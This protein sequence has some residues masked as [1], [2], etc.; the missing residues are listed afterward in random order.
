MLEK[1][2]FWLTV[3]TYAGSLAL[4]LKASLQS[5][6][7][8][9]NGREHNADEKW[10]LVAFLCH[11]AILV[12]RAA[13]S[14]HAPFTGLC[15]SLLIFSWGTTFFTIIARRSFGIHSMVNVAVPLV[16]A[17]LL[18]TLAT[19]TSTRPLPPVLRSPWLMIH[20]T[21]AIM[22]YGAFAAA[23]AVGVLRLWQEY[24]RKRGD[25]SESQLTD[26]ARLTS[27]QE[28]A[29][30][31]LISLGFPLM[32]LVMITGSIWANQSW[33]TYWQWDPKETWG[34][35]TTIVY[36]IYMHVQK[37]RGLSGLHTAWFSLIGFAF[38]MF[39]YLGVNLLLNG[40]HSYA[41]N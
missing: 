25:T 11:T 5:S 27:K 15:E 36:G 9:D 31:R 41:A 39:C 8:C 12:E 14:G 30:H 38:V 29:T 22:A 10:L 4:A 18:G 32:V 24:V 19:D 35:I 21:L 6:Q 33:G 40:M 2:T 28:T 17:A 3:A 34:L 37:T 20:V 13:A 26:S 16:L 1:I 7:V 23:A